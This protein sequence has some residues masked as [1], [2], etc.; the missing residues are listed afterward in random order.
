MTTL[1][2]FVVVQNGQIGVWAPAQASEP[3][4]A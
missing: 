1:A 3:T 2:R 4:Q